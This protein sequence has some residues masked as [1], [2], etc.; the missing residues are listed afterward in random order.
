MKFV[1]IVPSPAMGCTSNAAL[2]A[3]ERHLRGSHTTFRRAQDS[4][5]RHVKYLRCVQW[6]EASGSFL[7]AEIRTKATDHKWHSLQAF[8][9]D[10]DRHLASEIESIAV[11]YRWRAG[12]CH[13]PRTR[14]P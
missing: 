5:W 12:R 11:Y 2:K 10:L 4:R 6:N 7:V 8:I 13:R 14:L 1:P 3:G 9:G